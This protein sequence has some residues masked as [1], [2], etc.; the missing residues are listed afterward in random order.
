MRKAIREYLEDKL[1]ALE[2]SRAEGAGDRDPPGRIIF[3]PTPKNAVEAKLHG[4]LEG[5]YIAGKINGREASDWAARFRS[6]L[7]APGDPGTVFLRIGGSIPAE[8]GMMNEPWP[9]E[10]LIVSIEP[11]TPPRDYDTGSLSLT[12]VEL[13]PLGTRL[14][15]RLDLS[16][17]AQSTVQKARKDLKKSP[18]DLIEFHLTR[19]LLPRVQAL[20]MSDER[21]GVF[22]LMDMDSSFSNEDQVRAVTRLR[23]RPELPAHLTVTWADRTYAFFTGDSGPNA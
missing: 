10:S 12:R 20:S 8:V 2:L 16:M 15:W 4:L 17:K 13:Y 11:G 14:H 5:L 19:T 21:G 23:P 1:R 9:Q 18:P 6:V 22:A 3:G 7:A